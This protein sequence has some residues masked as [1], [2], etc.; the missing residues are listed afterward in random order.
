[1][2]DDHRT[3]VKFTGSGYRAHC[4]TPG[5]LWIGTHHRIFK[6]MGYGQAL[7]LRKCETLARN[8][9]DR[10]KADQRRKAV[11]A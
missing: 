2:N 10:H 5:C 3:F 1:M 7:A 8:D 4:G 6:Y 9:A 11:D